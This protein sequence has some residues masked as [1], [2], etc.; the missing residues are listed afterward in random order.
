MCLIVLELQSQ[1]DRQL[2]EK[3]ATQYLKHKA[4][5][6]K[7]GE[8]VGLVLAEQISEKRNKSLIKRIMGKNGI[9]YYDTP[10]IVDQFVNFYKEL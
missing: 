8:S 6:Y 9:L 7:Y 4:V 5:Q 3:K 1:A 2:R 10:S